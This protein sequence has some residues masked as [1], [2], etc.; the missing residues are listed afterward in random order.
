MSYL[1]F[2]RNCCECGRGMSEGYLLSDGSTYCD[3]NCLVAAMKKERPDYKLGTFADEYTD[4][5]EDCYT[6]WYDDID[7]A[8]Y[9]FDAV[10]N[11]YLLQD[12]GTFSLHTGEL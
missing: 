6:E 5:G 9:H 11:L 3:E 8:D 1:K 4:D 12:D 2:A 10:G 7:Y